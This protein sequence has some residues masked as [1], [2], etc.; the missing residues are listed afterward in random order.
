MINNS[1]D[2]SLH[3]PHLERYERELHALHSIAKLFNTQSDQEQLMHEVLKIIEQNLNMTRVAIILHT[4][5][6]NELVVERPYTIQSSDR[7][8]YRYQQDEEITSHVLQTGHT[9]II[10]RIQE[11]PPIHEIINNRNNMHY[12]NISFI[13]VPIITGDEVIGTLS[14]DVHHIDHDSLTKD[15]RVL[16][17]ISNMIAHDA[18]SRQLTKLKQS[19]LEEEHQR[20]RTSGTLKMRVNQL[21][22]E[23]IMDALK[24]S[25]GN[26]N[27]ASRELGITSRMVRYKIQNLKIDYKKLAGKKKI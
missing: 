18:K 21:E 8:Q 15:E 2:L 1:S 16:S 3:F 10:P 17:I 20:L 27:A 19:I 7:D 5:D 9:K 25:N 6:G 12:Q 14:T 26:I 22:R 24:R 13:C 11:E 23:V 4:V